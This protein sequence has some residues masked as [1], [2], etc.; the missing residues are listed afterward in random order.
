[1]GRLA[2]YRFEWVLPGH[3]QRVHLPAAEMRH[4]IE[5]LAEAMRGRSQ[6]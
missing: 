6:V 5:R 2:A 4:Q 3:G 1:M